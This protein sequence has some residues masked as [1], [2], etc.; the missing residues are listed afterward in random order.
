MA[1]ASHMAVALDRIH[2]LNQRKQTEEALRQSEAGLREA[3]RLGRLGSWNWDATTDIITWSEEYYHIY[4]LDPTQRPPGYEE[5]LKAYTPE[6]AARLDAAVKRNMETGEPYVIDLE[7]VHPDAPSR[8]ITARSETK[9]NDKGQIVGL[10]GTAQDITERKQAEDALRASEIRYR[11]LVELAPYLIA[12]HFNGN[13]VFVNEAGAKLF[14]AATPEQVI[15]QP[16]AQFVSPAHRD[17]SAERIKQG[18]ALGERSPL[19][20]Q[21]VIRLDGTEIDVEVA[22]VAFPYRDGMAI[23]IVMQD[24]TERK[25]AEEALRR[26]NR[27][28]Q[29]LSNCN[30]VLIRA[31]DE[32]TL[33]SDIC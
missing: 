12:V 18:L 6:S 7:L 2:L 9:R 10:R 24:I 20:E 29:A 15:G 31:E 13:L 27:E 8:W 23:Q 30:Q 25:R 32:Q 16:V 28:L 4:G 19:Y 26:L 33:L 3:Q 21:K 22:G 1:L 5:H 17:V 11:R 14:G